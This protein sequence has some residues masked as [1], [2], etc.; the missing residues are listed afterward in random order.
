MLQSVCLFDWLVW[1]VWTP[2]VFVVVV[3]SFVCLPTDTHATAHVLHLFTYS[4][5]HTDRH[6]CPTYVLH[7]FTYSACHTDRHACHHTRPSPILPVN[8]KGEQA[9][10]GVSHR[11]VNKERKHRENVDKILFL[12]VYVR[13]SK[14]KWTMPQ[15]VDM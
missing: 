14:N 1:V 6:A 8:Q 13:Q 11:T 15:V 3:L 2:F 12:R 4:A 10:L 5:C 7:L 9:L